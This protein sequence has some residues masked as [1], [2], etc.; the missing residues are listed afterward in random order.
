MKLRFCHCRHCN[1]ARKSKWWQAKVRTARKS[2]KQYTRW[3]LK[4]GEY[5]DLPSEISVPYAA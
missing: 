5:D 3:R 4:Q 1:R 2:A